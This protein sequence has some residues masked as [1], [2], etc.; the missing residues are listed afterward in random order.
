MTTATRHTDAAEP[1]G[2]RPPSTRYYGS[3]YKLLDWIW[4]KIGHL[5][6]ATV[7]DAFSGSGS[8]AHML[9][10]KGKQVTCND[11]L[12]CNYLSA[13]ALIENDH[14]RLS[15]ATIERLIRPHPQRGYDDFITRTFR[16]I[17]FLPRENRWLD[18]VCRNIESIRNRYAAALAW[19][20]LFQSAMAKRPFNLFHRKNLYMRTARVARGFG[21][22]ATWDRPFEEHFRAFAAEAN[23]AV[24]GNGTT[25]RARLGDALE[26]DGDYDLVYIDPPYVNSA[27]VGVDYY[28]FYHFLEG[29][30]DYAHW[31]RRVDYASKHRR[32][33][34][35][36]SPWIHP[37]KV[38]EALQRLLE[39]FAKSI[40]VLSYRSDGIPGRAE[41]VRLMKRVKA[42]VRVYEP[43]RRYQYVLSTNRRS[44]ELLLVGLP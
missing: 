22:K 23:A 6:F 31:P 10:A 44:T 13:V 14:V 1:R 11:I 7:L 41:L 17:Y 8:V 15:P 12:R 37:K 20:A 34:P 36:P 21:N 2:I 5:D 9:K 43:P 4:S 27:G 24:F 16:G 32:L 25:C 39:R 28:G 30:V 38:A 42:N 35:I 29:M 18:V 19:H 3:K 40:L 33:K 26:V